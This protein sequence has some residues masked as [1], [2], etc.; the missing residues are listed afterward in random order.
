MVSKTNTHYLANK[1]KN[2][3]TRKTVKMNTK[4]H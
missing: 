4:G 1:K 3:K 2:H